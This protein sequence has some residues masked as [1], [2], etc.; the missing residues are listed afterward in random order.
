[1]KKL[2]SL[3]SVLSLMAFSSVKAEMTFGIGLMAGNVKTSGTETEGTAADT[4]TRSKS[5]EEFF[6]G[7][8]IFVETGLNNGMTV[9]LSYVPLDIELGSGKRTDINGSDPAENDDGERKASADLTDLITLYTNI[10]VG[11]AGGYALLGAHYTKVKASTTLPNST[12]GSENVFGAQIGYG[13]KSD[14]GKI[15]LFYSEFPD[16]E[17][18]STGGNSN[19]V[20]ADADAITLRVSYG[21]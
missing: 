10:P 14:N 6:L 16:I 13:I 9:G 20:S 19:K 15:E 3:L 8:D 7:A 1:M 21:F 11:D 5:V 4:S 2:I 17:L 12:Y 18:T